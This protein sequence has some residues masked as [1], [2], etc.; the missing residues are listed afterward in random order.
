MIRNK[1]L[2]K[3]KHKKA[4]KVPLFKFIFNLAHFAFTQPDV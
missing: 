2:Y 3:L 4:R 1:T